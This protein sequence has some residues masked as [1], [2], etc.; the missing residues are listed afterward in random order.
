MRSRPRSPAGPVSPP[1]PW[2]CAR[3]APGTSGWSPTRCP[4]RATASMR[5][6]CAT[7]S[8]RSC[9]T[10]WCPPPYWPW[11]PFRSPPTASS[12][13][14]R[15]RIR[16]SPARER[17]GRR[18]PRRSRCCADS[19]PRSSNWPRCRW[20]TTSSPWAGTPCSPPGWC[21]A[22][23]PSWGSMWRC[24]TCSTRRPSPR[25]PGWSTGPPGRAPRRRP[26]S[27]PRR[28]RWR[29]RSA[30][31][32]S[33]TSWTARTA[34]TTWVCRCASPDGWTAARST[35][36]CTTSSPATRACA[37][38]SPTATVCPP[39]SCWTPT[40]PR[41]RSGSPKW[42]RSGWTR[43]CRR[44]RGAVSTSAPNCRS[45]RTCWC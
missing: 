20:T 23:R 5:P 4:P 22:S 15:C 42:P 24:A 7:S 28:C 14:R 36:R 26:G 30:D 21:C 37:P 44:W 6:R 17:A 16:S 2:S 33:S 29:T 9:P 18:G 3:T 34:P 39:R 35:P 31:C 19:S 11:T 38:S 32:G 43:R 27:A 8:P 41:P 45:A 12:T 1:P 13:A 25:W 40:R 10:T